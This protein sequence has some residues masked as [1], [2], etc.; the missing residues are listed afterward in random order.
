VGNNDGREIDFAGERNGRYV[1]VQAVSE[2]SGDKVVN[3]EFGNLKVGLE[4]RVLIL[5]LQTAVR[6]HGDRTKTEMGGFR[7][8]LEDPRP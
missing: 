3:R 1:Y 5:G 6:R 8:I 2:L 4:G 7:T